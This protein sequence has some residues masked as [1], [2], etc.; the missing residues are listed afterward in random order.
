MFGLNGGEIA[1]GKLA[2][3]LLINMDNERFVPNF[4][5]NSNWIYAS[6][7]EAIDTMIC[8]G[9]IVMRHRHV[10]GEEEIISSAKQCAKKWM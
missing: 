8:N 3:A 7:C 5:F 6:S 9:K 1:V 2:D 10:N 4:N